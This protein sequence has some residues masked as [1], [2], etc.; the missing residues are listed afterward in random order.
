MVACFNYLG[1]ESEL[2]MLAP[3]IYNTLTSFVEFNIDRRLLFE[4]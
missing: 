2:E 1:N 3:E 4:S